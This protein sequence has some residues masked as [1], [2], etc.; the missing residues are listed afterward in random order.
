MYIYIYK[1]GLINKIYVYFY[2]FLFK[3]SCC[4]V[5]IL[6]KEFVSIY[7]ILLATFIINSLGLFVLFELSNLF[8]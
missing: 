5:Y 3:Y 8:S 2:F 6:V 7:E 4:Q 1:V